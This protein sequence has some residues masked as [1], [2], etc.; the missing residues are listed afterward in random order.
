MRRREF[1]AA[2]GGAA[3][4]PA[5]VQ[6]QQPSVLLIGYLSSRSF[7]KSQHLVDA[8]QAGLHRKIK[9][10]PPD[11]SHHHDSAIA[12][13]SV[14]QAASFCLSGSETLESSSVHDHRNYSKRRSSWGPVHVGYGEP[15]VQPRVATGYYFR[16]APPA[17]RPVACVLP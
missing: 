3:T 1:V 11:L 9:P 5:A 10:L 7:G 15:Q 14:P 16:A 8:F 13:S 6:A 17:S 4:W 12:Q 2:L